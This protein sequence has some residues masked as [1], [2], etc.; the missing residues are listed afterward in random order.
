MQ[1][2]M[3]EWRVYFRPT[4]TMALSHTRAD[5]R[6]ACGDRAFARGLD[7]VRSQ[8]VLDIDL[9]ETETDWQINSRVRGNAIYSQ[10]I[11]VS[12]FMDVIEIEGECS[13]PVGY[14]CKHVAAVLIALRDDGQT[15]PLARQHRQ[16]DF[17]LNRLADTR[18]PEQWTPGLG[19]QTLLYVLAPSTHKPQQVE[20]RLLITRLLKNGKG[21]GKPYTLPIYETHG[22]R[23]QKAAQPV[24]HAIVRLLGSLQG[25]S[26]L[27]LRGDLGAMAL[28]RMLATGR[29]Y[30]QNIKGQALEPGEPRRLQAAWHAE[31]DRLQLRLDTE[32]AGAVPLIVDPPAY[33]DPCSATVGPL[34]LDAGLDHRTLEALLEAPPLSP[35]LADEVSDKLLQSFPE[36]GLPLPASR[37]VQELAD[38]TLTP[39]LRLTAHRGDDGQKRQLVHLL[40]LQFDY[41]GRRVGLPFDPVSQ[42][43]D[44][45]VVTRI[46]RDTDSEV[47]ALRRLLAFGFE[48]WHFTDPSQPAFFLPAEQIGD[49]ARRWQEFLDQELPALRADGWLVEQDAAFAL[50]FVRADEL[51]VDIEE[52]GNW[53]D[54]GIGVEIEGRRVDLVPLLAQLAEQID[55]PE[56]LPDEQ[57]LMLEIGEAQWLEL[58]AA[59]LKPLLVTLFDLFDR[60]APDAET[61]QLNRIDAVRL[62]GLDEGI[63]WRGG[64]ALR[65]L[66][67]RLA[68]LEGVPAVSAP[69]GLQ[70]ELRPY[71]LQGLAWLQFLRETGF[72]G[73]LADDMGLG[74]TVQALAHLLIEKLAGRLDR[75]A[76]VIAP[77]SLMANWRHEAERFT[78]SL[79]V[80]TLHGP[81]RKALF[82]VIDTHDLVLTT[83]PLLSR[84]HEILCKQAFHC[85][86]LDEA[87]TI[88]NPRAK[89]AQIVRK[90]DTRHRLCLTG[91][92]M[93]NHLGELWSLF[94]FLAPGYLG[95]MQDFRRRFRVPIE[96]HGDQ[97]RRLALQRRIAPFLLRRTK[98]AVA[99]ELPDKVEIV[100]TIALDDAQASLYESVRASMDKK[101]RETLGRKGLAR[102]HITILDALLK[103]R[104]ICCDPRLV[105]LEHAHKLRRSAKLELLLEML[106][107]LLDEGRRIL[108]FSQFT[109]MLSLIEAEL[110]HLEISYTKL[111]GQ[112]RKREQVIEEFR[113]GAVPLFLI[114]LKAGGVGLNLTEADTVIHYDPW[115]NPAVEKQATDRAHRIGQSSTVF[116]YKLVTEGTV[117]EKIL[118]LQARKAELANGLY[119]EG[120]DDE[121]LGLSQEDLQ[122]LL[123][124]LG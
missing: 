24:D 46:L 108:L 19:E 14:N 89:A 21:Y 18:K 15:Q 58:P 105:K 35:E 86:I 45:D 29:T 104:Q 26:A 56:D 10:E 87:Q 25:Y 4:G 117:E 40:Q 47:S 63:V 102:S 6:A 82:D 116:V 48:P 94:H 55:R 122:E 17:W 100:R 121:G 36:M 90:L 83:Y 70:A 79:R 111:T 75:P 34:Q 1:C 123:E 67:G 93:E 73:V 66:A 20:V 107:E 49:S 59:R 2:G 32:P 113:S 57:L 53:F 88:K 11:H 42:L 60:A 92:P 80:L 54:L 85:V 37:T 101:V 78:P 65:E 84:D 33:V 109:S 72:G 114:S 112:T 71:Q 39:V 95:D 124:P 115:W 51:A 96:E 22:P 106:P 77:T 50:R 99:S 16:I 9:Q 3:V 103:L 110:K 41:A 76:L 119:R 23:L 5:I 118:A 7:Y 31:G 74:K 30:W 91:T 43:S 68:S 97:E 98:Q 12:E 64:E 81:Q 44:A 61:L 38:L 28:L 27:E 8:R 69:P 52:R 13:C 120:Q 62:Q